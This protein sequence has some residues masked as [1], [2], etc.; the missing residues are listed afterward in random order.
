MYKI[1]YSS[2]K[3]ETKVLLI[4]QKQDNHWIEIQDDELKQKIEETFFKLTHFNQDV[5]KVGYGQFF[6]TNKLRFITGSFEYP[7]NL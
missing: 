1:N 2:G 3:G 5:E 6:A 4:S 7:E